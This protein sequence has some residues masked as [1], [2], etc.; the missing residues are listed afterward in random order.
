VR[1]HLTEV[2]ALALDLAD[3]GHFDG[4]GEVI[5]TSGGSAFFDQVVEILGAPWPEGLP[6]LPVLRSGAAITH[7]QGFYER[8]SPLGAHPRLQGPQL[9]PAVRAWARVISRPEPRLA[10][11]T[12]GK[13][14]VP[15]DIDLPTPELRRRDDAT[16]PLTGC[17]MFA[18]ND[19]HGFLRLG[20]DA[21]VEVGDWV[22]L[23]LSHPCTTFDK[24]PL[25]PVVGADGET[26]VDLIRTF[27]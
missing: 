2:R 12:A 1:T 4:L 6:V 20:T 23:A 5:V 9:R 18:I 13:R 22:G 17:T 11:V 19:H 16:T 27:F 10:F 8:V 26:V 7:D 15:Y 21:A 25:V 24:A 14:D 3:R